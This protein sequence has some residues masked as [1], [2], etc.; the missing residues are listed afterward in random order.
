[1]GRRYSIDQNNIDERSQ[2][3]RS[4]RPIYKNAKRVIIWLG[5]SSDDSHNAL[6]LVSGIHEHSND[7][8]Y[9][10]QKIAD[11]VSSQ[12]FYA[13]CRVFALDYW[14]R[15]WDVQEVFS[16]KEIVVYY[17]SDS[18]HWQT[19]SDV[20]KLLFDKY[21]AQL[22]GIFRRHPIMRNYILWYGPYA[23]RLVHGDLLSDLPELFEIVLQH[24]SKEASDPRD[25]I[26]AFVGVSKQ[27]ESYEIDYSSSVPY[28]YMNFVYHYSAVPEARYYLLSEENWK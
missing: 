20:Q 23:L 1:M 9:I 5:P 12:D 15:V 25:K 2:Q 16:A 4:M 17:G 6:G 28:I 19:L 8:A 7:Q 24:A 10:E 26:Y 3:A 27:N 18:I 11:P 21:D 22:S 14:T 13:L